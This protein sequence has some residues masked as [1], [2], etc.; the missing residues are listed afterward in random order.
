LAYLVSVALFVVGLKRLATVRTARQGNL[1]LA[2]GM[3]LAV[4]VT[5]VEQ[6][7]V[8]PTWIAV[9]SL[10]GIA[11]GVA[12][13]VRASATSMPQVVARFNGFGG[14]GSALVALAVFFEQVIDAAATGEAA[15]GTL[16]AASAT[17]LA[18]S[19]VIGAATFSGSV[20][21]E[22][23]LWGRLGG[24]TRIPAR[25][26]LIVLSALLA[27]AAAVAALV[28][29]D[30]VT[31]AVA[32]GALTL[33]SAL[34]GVLAVGPVGGADMPVMISLLNSLSGLA[35][36]AT[37]FALGNTLLV[38]GGT[39]VGAAGLMLT[40]IMCVAMNRTL[41]NVFAGGLG[42]DPA[43]SGDGDTYEN[44]VSSD[45]EEAAMVLD[46]ARS[47]VIVP[48]YGLAAAR[49]QQA[50]ADLADALAARDVEVRFAI[51]PVA[52]RMPGHMN[53][54]L[55]EADVP[56]ERLVEMDRI[57][58]DFATTDVVIVVG[59]NDVVNPAAKQA[60]GSPIAGM[61]ILDIGDAQTILVVK[62][63]L[64]AG[65]SGIKNE[66]FERDNCSMLFGDA[67]QVLDD[68]VRELSATTPA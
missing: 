54:V 1:L 15:F 18:L 62:R 37:G 7:R 39:I 47:V 29:V 59:A 65:Y 24:L 33:L 38:M 9:G 63:S 40:R 28:I 13:V 11:V 58:R 23:K 45:P 34:V 8:T 17:T 56:Y 30:P 51:H 41:W 36:A 27:V 35:A 3:L 48:G 53:V 55:A 20:V 25:S 57:N 21:A 12:M 42:D 32:V 50:A 26:V 66:L 67:K 68:L 46:V 10:A 44:I 43:A 49:A 64:S 52:G 31:A 60:S 61:P 14:A 22:A 4:I 16:G 5:L 19:V 2:G 6:G